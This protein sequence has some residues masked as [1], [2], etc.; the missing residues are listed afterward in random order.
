MLDEQIPQKIEVEENR[1]IPAPPDEPQPP[2]K[3]QK[4][5]RPHFF[6]ARSSPQAEVELSILLPAERQRLQREPDPEQCRNRQQILE[7]PA[8]WPG[9]A[10]T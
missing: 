9:Q 4:D 6:R 7:G 1:A 2:P 5:P 8:H 10:E 3:G